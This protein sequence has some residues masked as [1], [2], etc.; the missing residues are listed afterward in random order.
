MYVQTSWV[1]SEMPIMHQ[2]T[3][4]ADE[5]HY[6]IIHFNVNQVKGTKNNEALGKIVCLVLSHKTAIC[7]FVCVVQTIDQELA[8]GHILECWAEQSG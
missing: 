2:G 6:E 3:W 8:C 5:E 4:S 1:V 7:L